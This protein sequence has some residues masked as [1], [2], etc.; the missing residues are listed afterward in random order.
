MTARDGL[1]ESHEVGLWDSLGNLLAETTVVTGD[2]LVNQ[3][4]YSD[5]TPV[6][7][8]A[9]ADYFVGALFTSGGRQRRFHG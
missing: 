7:L 1:A 8:A 4:R 2:P 3:W 9:G 6:T 5:V